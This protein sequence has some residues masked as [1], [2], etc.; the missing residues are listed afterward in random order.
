[1]VEL[2]NSI[3]RNEHETN[4]NKIDTER[5]LNLRISQ[6]TKYLPDPV[7]ASEFLCKFSTHLR[8]DKALFYTMEIIFS[9]STDCKAC[10]EN[11]VIIIRVIN[12]MNFSSA[13]SSFVCD[14]SSDCRIEETGSSCD[15]K[16]VL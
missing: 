11:T 5:E 16:F 14:F 9:P 13:T 2:L 6:L 4:N 7:K 12:T 3:R 8:G 1:V 15:D 10:A